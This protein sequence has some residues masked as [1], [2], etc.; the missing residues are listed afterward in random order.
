[1]RFSHSQFLV[2]WVGAP[3]LVPDWLDTS[4]VI[5]TSPMTSNTSAG[6]DRIIIRDMVHLRF[7]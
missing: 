5:Q 6:T 1:M 3:F 2:E 7:A 4:I